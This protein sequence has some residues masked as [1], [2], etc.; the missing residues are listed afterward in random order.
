MFLTQCANFLKPRPA[1]F[2]LAALVP[3]NSALFAQI[4]IATLT[5]AVKDTTGGVVPR[6]RIE[7]TNRGT[8]L[9]R[10]AVSDS[11]GQ[12][13]LSDVPAGHYQI[14]VSLP[15]FKVWVLPD[16][17]LQVSQTAIVDAILAVGSIDQEVTVTAS[18]PLLNAATS[19]VGQVVNTSTVERMPLNGRSFWQLAQ[20]TPGAIPAPVAQNAPSNGNAIRARSVNVSIN[21]MS[22]IYTGWSLDGASITETQLG[23]TLVQPNVDAIQEF[24]VEGA[25]MAAEYGHTPTLINASLKSGT[26]ALHGS[27]F[28]F[29]RN[30]IFDA[31]NFFYIPP[32]GSKL[33][34]EPLR[35][36][37]YGFT[38]GGPIRR[39]QT[40]YFVSAENLHTDTSNF[41]TIDPA[42]ATVFQSRGNSA[43]DAGKYPAD[44]PE[45]AN[46]SIAFPP[47]IPPPY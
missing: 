12:Y 28:E 25:N 26:N 30:D 23:G 33:T 35:R 20:L 44:G 19:S 45:G 43:I 22:Q 41:V 1:L 31:R 3:L 13:V 16:F 38:L 9:V 6:A 14:K 27:L 15:G 29:L 5:G 10:S 40:F 36:N 34:N 47:E 11:S 21:G 4:T 2:L 24:K 42:A 8:G 18:A 46:D 39:D 37:Q 7:V 17:E 32:P